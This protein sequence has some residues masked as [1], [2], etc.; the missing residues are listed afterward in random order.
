MSDEHVRLAQG[1]AVEPVE[2]AGPADGYDGARFPEGVRQRA[3]VEDVCLHRFR[4]TFAITFLRNGG[5]VFAPPSN[6][7]VGQPSLR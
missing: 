2:Q 7:L 6:L 4:H 3:G 1:L 5:N